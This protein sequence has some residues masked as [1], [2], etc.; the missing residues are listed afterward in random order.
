MSFER[1]QYEHIYIEMNE[2]KIYLLV[3]RPGT[4]VEQGRDVSPISMMSWSIVGLVVLQ[5][6]ELACASLFYPTV[7]IDT[8]LSLNLPER[9]ILAFSALYTFSRHSVCE[10]VEMSSN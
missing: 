9:G 4:Q 1:K 10:T 5:A 6:V 3:P 8:S 2:D 7:L